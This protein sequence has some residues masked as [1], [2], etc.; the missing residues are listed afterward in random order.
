MSP[1]EDRKNKKKKRKREQG[2][3]RQINNKEKDDKLNYVNN[4]IE[5]KWSKYS[6]WR[7]KIIIFGKRKKPDN[8]ILSIRNSLKIKIYPK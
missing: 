6:C 5:W 7:V 2:E 4:H 8:F 3:C 1:E